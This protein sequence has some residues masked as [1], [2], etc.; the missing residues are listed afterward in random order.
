MRLKEI[1]QLKKELQ[2]LGSDK[3][4]SQIDLMIRLGR[5][6]VNSVEDFVEKRKSELFFKI[7]Q[8]EKETNDEDKE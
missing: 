4:R 6:K 5:L 7:G 2:H 3:Q 1:E 8:L